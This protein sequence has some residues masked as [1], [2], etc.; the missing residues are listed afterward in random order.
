MHALCRDS[1]TAWAALGSVNYERKSSEVGN[2]KFRRSLYFVKNMTAGEVITADSVRS[3]RPGYGLPP[4][5]LEFLL[6]AR[7]KSDVRYG[8]P[9]TLD[10]I[11]E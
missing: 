4:G 5:K 1:K 10:L 6:G 8:M 2:V 9:V 11:K 7:L 3:V